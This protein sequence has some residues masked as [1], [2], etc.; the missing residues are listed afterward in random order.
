MTNQLG[1]CL[2]MR[3]SCSVRHAQL[4]IATLSCDKV[5]GVAGVATL[6]RDKVA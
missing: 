6:S 5:A 3:Q 4:H 1:E 2:F